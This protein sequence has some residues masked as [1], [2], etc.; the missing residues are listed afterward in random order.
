MQRWILG[1]ISRQLRDLPDDIHTH[2]LPA[3][4]LLHRPPQIPLLVERI[5]LQFLGKQL[6]AQQQPLGHEIGEGEVRQRDPAAVVVD[7]RDHLGDLFLPGI[8]QDDRGP[9][10]FERSP[11]DDQRR[12]DMNHSRGE[13]RREG[14]REILDAVGL[15][16]PTAAA[17]DLVCQRRR[18]HERARVHVELRTQCEQRAEEFVFLDH[19]CSAGESAARD[20][21]P[22]WTD[23]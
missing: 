23:E 18:E 13:D 3:S 4:Q 2:L 7:V 5:R 15:K 6:L 16:E 22:L 12:I 10:R 19:A 11:E 8:R 14:P 17:N 9:P 20:R 21:I 1:R